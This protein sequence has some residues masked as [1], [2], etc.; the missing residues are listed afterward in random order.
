MASKFGAN[1]NEIVWKPAAKFTQKLAK[2]AVKCF[3]KVPKKTEIPLQNFGKKFWKF[4]AKAKILKNLYTLGANFME[5]P[6]NRLRNLR[7]N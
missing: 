3:E 7:I 2:F 5:Q 4:G 1:F 6:E